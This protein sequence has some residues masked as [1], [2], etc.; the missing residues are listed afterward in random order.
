M[1]YACFDCH[2][3]FKRAVLGDSATCPHCGEEAKEM[4]RNFRAPKRSDEDEWEKIRILY[5]GGVR[6]WGA[7]SPNLGPFPDT[8]EEALE[9]VR[10]NRQ[11]LE[12]Q[13]ANYRKLLQDEAEREEKRR[14]KKRALREK[15]KQAEQGGGPKR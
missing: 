2:K 6:F 7:Q 8:R 11:E 4:G 9:F 14:G 1:Q 15:R 13:E 10:R 12:C 5:D 3:S